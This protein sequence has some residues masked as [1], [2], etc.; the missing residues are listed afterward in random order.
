[1]K[2]GFLMT[3]ALMLSPFAASAQTASTTASVNIE[4]Y[5]LNIIKLRDLNFGSVIPS[6]SIDG[7]MTLSPSGAPSTTSSITY[8]L[9]SG[10]EQASYSI[11]GVPAARVNVTVAPATVTLT[12]PRGTL[13]V[14]NFILSQASPIVL[15]GSTG[16][17]F[18]SIGATL[19]VNAGQ[20]P[21]NYTG[22]F[23]VTVAY[24]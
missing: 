4:N 18:F 17:A 19:F 16:T 6:A 5:A 14:G 2:Y 22:T 11:S 21:G 15:D 7:T 23:D 24:N 8:R 12:S 10:Y 3:A 1:M 20:L 9:N 13:T